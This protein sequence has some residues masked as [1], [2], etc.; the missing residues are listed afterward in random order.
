MDI[1]FPRLIR[2]TSDGRM[3]IRLLAVSHFVD[4]K[5]RTEIAHLL[6]VSR[7]SVNK[8]VKNF[9]NDGVEG[10][11]EKPH[12]G[13]PSRLTKEQ[14]S[15]VK[16]FVTEHAIKPDGGRLQG[17]DVKR[18]IYDSF[19]VTYQKTMVYTLLQQLNLSWITT[20]SK[21]PKQSLQAQDDFKKIRNRNDQ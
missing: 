7:T 8:W 21:H 15:Q 4:G 18:F 20:R 17:A 16:L 3:K 1:D 19:G 12:T 14:L 10:L 9:L 11:A 2:T 13:R 5:S 6:K